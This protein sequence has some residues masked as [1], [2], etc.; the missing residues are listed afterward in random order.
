MVAKAVQDLPV[1]RVQTVNA[2]Q[3]STVRLAIL[4][5]LLAVVALNTGACH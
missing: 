2:E 4:L 3:L 1:R 5:E